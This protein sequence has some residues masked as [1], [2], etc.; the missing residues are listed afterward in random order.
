MQGARAPAVLAVD[1]GGTK[2]AVALVRGAEVLALEQGRTPA[3][4]GPDAVVAEVVVRAR[5]LL[6]GGLT[7]PD[8][9]GV[10]CAG[11]VVDGR[12]RAMSPELL[13]GWHDYPLVERLRAEIELPVSALNDAQAA[14]LGEARHGAGRG[15]DSLLFV[16]VSTGVGGG[17]VLGGRLWQGASGLAG[18]VG[19]MAGGELERV[20]SGTALARLA[21]EAGHVGLGAREVIEE[22]EAGAGWALRL[23]VGAADALARALADVRV[24]VDPEVV[25]LGGGVG[26]NAGF[27]RAVVAAV[28][29]SDPRTRLRVVP[30]S[31]GAAAGLVGAACW[32]GDQGSPSTLPH[33]EPS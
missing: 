28:E 19:H 8:R 29:R 9:V 32:S 7:S 15:H 18:H 5:R 25:V 3:A 17:L 13:P 22:A 2:V 27:R 6:V 14:A 30:A 24:L 21:A 33:G 26:L 23:V 4:A 16:T 12:V 20:A 31:L 1:I 11:V 10:A